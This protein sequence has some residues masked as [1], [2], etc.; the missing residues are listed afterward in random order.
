M[1]NLKKGMIKRGTAKELYKGLESDLN[2][3]G[4]GF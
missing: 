4:S 1:A 3:M 2:N